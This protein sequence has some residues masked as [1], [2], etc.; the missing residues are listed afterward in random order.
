MVNPPW[1]RRLL[2]LLLVLAALLAW[3]LSRPPASQRSARFLL[4]AIAAYQARVSPWLPV[5]GVRCRF[6]P[7]CSRYAQGAIARHGALGGL[8]RAMWRLARCGPWTPLGTQ[9]PP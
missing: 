4:A 3:D 7:T 8:P 1:A 5:L 6:E 9:D 2:A